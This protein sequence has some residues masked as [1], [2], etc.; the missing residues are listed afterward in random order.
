M[1]TNFDRSGEG[2]WLP[3]PRRP[4]G[5]YADFTGPLKQYAPEGYEKLRK[6]FRSKYRWDANA[7]TPEL[8]PAAG[9]PRAEWLTEPGR[10]VLE[11]VE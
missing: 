2:Q 5:D 3:P 9:D 11:A 1:A 10:W 8:R 4:S 6:L 7:T